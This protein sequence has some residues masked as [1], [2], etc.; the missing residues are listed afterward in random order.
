LITTPNTTKWSHFTFLATGNAIT[1][2]ELYEATDR[3]GTTLQTVYN[4]NR[5]SATPATLTVHKGYSGGTTD[6]ERIWIRKSGSSSSQSRSS[7]EATHENEMPLKQNTKYILRITSGT[8]ANLTN[9]MLGWYEH[10]DK[11]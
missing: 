4:S 3:I 10:T 8:A 6:G 7:S 5:N 11:N 9:L 2:V 1:Q